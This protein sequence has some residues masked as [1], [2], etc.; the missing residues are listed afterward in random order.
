MIP[1]RTSVDMPRPLHFLIE[2]TRGLALDQT[3]RRTAMSALIMGALG[4]VFV[5]VFLFWSLFVEHPIFFA[6]WWLVCGWLLL[7]A[8][9]L[10]IYDLLVVMRSGREAKKRE[11]RRILDEMDCSDGK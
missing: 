3:L 1:R 9:L 10:A 2:I 11:Q 6:I 7:T 8:A 5:G 4:M